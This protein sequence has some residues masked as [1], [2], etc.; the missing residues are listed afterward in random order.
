MNKSFLN[1][2]S[3]FLIILC[4]LFIFIP[5]Y[6]VAAT[7]IQ[8]EHKANVSVDKVWKIKFNQG[9]NED[10]LLE[11]VAVYNPIGIPASI[12]VSYDA[13]N[14]TVTVKPPASGYIPGQT[15]SLQI[16]EKLRDLNDYPLKAPVIKN[17]TIAVP[18]NGPL[19][20]TVNKKYVY[21]QYYN[22]LDQ[23]LDVESKAN[24]SS[25]IANY[26]NVDASNIDIYEYLNPKNF[27]SHDYA[28]Y[29]F[30]TL[31]YVK[32]ITA[33]ELDTAL[34]GKGIL[35]GQGKTF[36]DACKEYDINP[37]YII[38]HALLETGN[39]TSVL[40]NGVD[41]TEVD[42]KPVSIEMKTYNMFGIGAFDDNPNKFGSE[43]AYTQ[44][45]FTP[46]IAI[47][48]GIKWIAE[49][50]I[51][52]IDYKQNT[53]YKMRWNPEIPANGT[54]RHQYATDIGWAYKQS[55]RIKQILDKCVNANLVFEIPQYK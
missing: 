13:I 44:G 10:K 42:G 53:L 18:D 50:Y 25:G 3:L 32:G 14:N 24:P 47:T 30:L 11:S 12:T 54:Y 27:E 33:E 2:L 9:I 28:V 19:I 17:F 45:W 37:A 51:N 34:I 48:Y 16:G 4:G 1:S 36:L 29:Q 7:V 22:T 21:K 46:E 55:Y 43:R 20:D 15:Y 5:N 41:V 8:M 49:R 38:A 23:M 39:G 31:N 52:N 35:E 26:S 40:A 6:V